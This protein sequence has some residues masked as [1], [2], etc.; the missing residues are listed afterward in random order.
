MKNIIIVFICIIIYA[1]TSSCEKMF[2]NFLDKAPGIDVTEETIFSSQTQV[3]TFVAGM[4]AYGIINDFP[5]YNN[6]LKNSS[7]FAG[8]C[9]EGEHIAAWYISNSWNAGSLSTSNNGDTKISNRWI[10][11]RKANI[12]LEKIDEVPAD[13]SYKDQVR[14]EALF[15]RALNYFDMFTFY[16]GVPLVD[17]RFEI[18]ENYKVSR[19]SIEETVNFI[20]KDCNDA[21]ALLPDIYPTSYYGRVTKGAALIL[22]AKT[23]LYAASPQ[24]N[25]GTP[26]LDLPG[27]NDLICY[28]NFDNNRWQLAADAAKAVIDWAPSGSIAL[29]T[30]E[31]VSKNYKA[32][33]EK[34]N[35]SECI[36]SY[37]FT[38]TVAKSS[39]PWKDLLPPS[40]YTG[41][42]GITIPFNFIKFYRKSDGKS[43]TW[44][45]LGG[46]DL[47]QKYAELEPRFH[48]TFAYNGSRWNVEFPIME[49]WEADPA[50]GIVA[51]R[52]IKSNYGGV[53]MHKLIPEALTNNTPCTPFWAVF[54]LAEAYLYYAEALNEAQGPVPAVYAA[55]NTIR[56]RSGLPNLSTGLTKEQFRDEV[57]L[58]WTIE[59]AYDNHRLWNVRRWLIADT[60][61]VMKGD[62]YGIKIYKIP[63]TTPQKF[64]YVPYVFESR[65]FNRNLYLNPFP[66]TEVDKEYLIQNP[67]W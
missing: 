31:G 26:Y 38:G 3:E 52:D 56:N 21:A 32:V 43:Q 47:N 13:Q 46:N 53:W 44:D 5:V 36:L 10:T 33:W 51:G 64:R 8:A 12:L 63:G 11:I 65:S 58:E 39:T 7:I 55:I 40:I 48:Q 24:F 27:H 30:S 18:G 37:N 35:N 50:N 57:R 49:C 17:K 1:I 6:L 28:G 67:G 23:L 4:Y 41:Q 2:G 14:G 22:K 20:V 29:V 34:P 9:D 16:G 25:T 62:M 19:S 66:R 54:R 60:E 61:G 45:P 15:I 42:A 59:M